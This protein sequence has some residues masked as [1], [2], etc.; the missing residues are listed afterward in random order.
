MTI[1]FYVNHLGPCHEGLEA[2]Y[3]RVRDKVWKVV[4][5]NEE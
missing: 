2:T 4:T 3:A 5:G 1:L